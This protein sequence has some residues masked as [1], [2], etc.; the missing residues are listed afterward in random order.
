MSAVFVACRWSMVGGIGVL[1]TLGVFLVANHSVE[2]V[3]NTPVL[4][5]RM[6]CLKQEGEAAHVAIWSRKAQRVEGKGLETVPSMMT[7]ATYCRSGAPSCMSNISS[8][9]RLTACIM[10]TLRAKPTHG[11]N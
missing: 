4:L 1:L 7:L 8:D 2:G 5:L 11:F 6:R 10:S 3:F 9:C